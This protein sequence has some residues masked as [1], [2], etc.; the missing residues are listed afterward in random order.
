MSLQLPRSL[1][2][3]LSFLA[4]PLWVV[5]MFWAGIPF[6]VLRRIY[7]WYRLPQVQR[8]AINANRAIAHRYGWQQV[9]TV[10]KAELLAHGLPDTP[11]NRARLNSGIRRRQR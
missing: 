5:V 3:L 9:E 4:M 2:I 11:A 10:I 8:D 7:R 1:R 6:L